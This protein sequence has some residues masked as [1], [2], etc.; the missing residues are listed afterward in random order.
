MTDDKPSRTGRL[1][2]SGIV[3]A[4]AVAVAWGGRDH[5][6]S[7]FANAGVDSKA[8][9][10]AA[11]TAQSR[12]AVPVLTEK[13]GEL[14]DDVVVQAIGT[15]R[16][17]RSVMLYPDANGEIVEFPVRAEK[18]VG[19]DEIILR[20]DSRNGALAVQVAETRVREAESAL[21]RAEKLRQSNVNSAA[22]VEDAAIVLERARL[23]LNQAKVALMDRSL[24]APF[25]GVA[26]IPKVEIGDRVST[27]TA[28][29][30]LDDRSTLIVEF[31]VAEKHLS[32]LSYDLPISAQTAAF[33]DQSIAGYIERIDS[34]VDPV[35]RT[36]LV[37]AAFDNRD[38]LLR[39]GMSFIVTLNLPG[40][41]LPAVPELALQ[42]EDGRSYIWRIADGIAERV[43]VQTRRRLNNTV[44]IEGDLQPGQDVVV[45]GVQRL[46]QGLAVTI[47][48]N[49]GA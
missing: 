20:L 12:S 32:R 37:R 14:P 49:T 4:I 9:T 33:P 31:D 44:L 19:K 11:Q 27:D 46:R 5:L 15:A 38:D 35:S 6:K 47:S 3:L 23:E 17:V 18:E 7:F 16:A 26:G 10:E 21:A 24:R 29:L 43:N 28:I 40:P 41:M 2:R 13:V 39:P 48:N 36:V 34:R 25:D 30:T 42:W 22:N 45:E 1:L 8:K